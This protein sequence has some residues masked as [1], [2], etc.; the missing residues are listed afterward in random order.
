[1]GGARCPTAHAISYAV[2]GRLSRRCAPRCPVHV[3]YGPDADALAVVPHGPMSTRRCSAALA[4]SPPGRPETISGS[5]ATRKTGRICSD[6][7][8]YPPGVSAT[9]PRLLGLRRPAPG[10][11]RAR[12]ASTTRT[13]RSRKSSR[14]LGVRAAR[15]PICISSIGDRRRA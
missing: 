6:L 14:S 11:A 13:K 7:R 10:R 4:V 1:M 3:Q 5:Q 2:F 9:D 12:L 8:H 15:M